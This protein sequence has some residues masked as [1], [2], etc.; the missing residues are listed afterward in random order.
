MRMELVA[1]QG[2]VDVDKGPVQRRLKTASMYA[3]RGYRFTWIQVKLIK[4]TSRS[5]NCLR[6]SF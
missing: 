1:R 5:V 3:E 4:C 2:G 6:S